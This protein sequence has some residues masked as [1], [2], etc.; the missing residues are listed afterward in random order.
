M[1]N[2]PKNSKETI[3]P[4]YRKNPSNKI[5]EKS[6]LFSKIPKRW[7]KDSIKKKNWKITWRASC[8]NACLISFSDAP[9]WIRNVRYWSVNPPAAAEKI[10]VLPLSPPRPFPFPCPFKARPFPSEEDEGAEVQEPIEAVVPIAIAIF[11][12]PKKDRETREIQAPQASIQLDA[13]K[14]LINLINGTLFRE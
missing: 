5:S 2:S 10:T 6:L 3:F 11:F 1:K 8:R 14:L 12:P 4:H 7:N 13:K 9:G